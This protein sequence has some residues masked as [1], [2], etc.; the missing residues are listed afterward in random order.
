MQ[1]EM[2]DV[3]I[4]YPA[5]AFDLTGKPVFIAATREKRPGVSLSTR[6]PSRPP[7]SWQTRMICSRSS[8]SMKRRSQR[9]CE[10]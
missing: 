4:D 8:C 9:A 2:H 5:S 7:Q 10:R 1:L 3:K 6:S